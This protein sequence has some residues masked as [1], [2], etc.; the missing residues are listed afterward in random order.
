M[1]IV[2]DQELDDL[3]LVL[4]LQLATSANPVGFSLITCKIISLG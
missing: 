3:T 2:L 4:I 1:E